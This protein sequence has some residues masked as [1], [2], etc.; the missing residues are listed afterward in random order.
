MNNLPKISYA[1]I[2]L[3]LFTFLFEVFPYLVFGFNG[4]LPNPWNSWPDVMDM[5][6]WM[7]A[8]AFIF[9]YVYEYLFN[10]LEP[11]IKAMYLSGLVLYIWGHG[12]HWAANSLNIA[13]CNT[14]SAY[15]LDE[16]F[17][18][19]V[20]YFG[21]LIT[22]IILAFLSPVL[23][24]RIRGEYTVMSLSAILFAFSCGAM[25]LEGQVVNMFLVAGFIIMIYLLFAI[26]KYK[27]ISGPAIFFLIWS[28]TLLI[29]L[30]GYY[31]ML[32]GFIQPSEWM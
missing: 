26:V 7:P 25:S 31:I 21:F 3:S 6:L 28:V 10:R 19:M 15:F 23:I 13:P 18:H 20:L 1:L 5:V 27:M 9:I 22:I 4:S 16:I 17:G 2:G 24:E 30:A 14:S 29:L 8:T 12:V 11:V 32:G